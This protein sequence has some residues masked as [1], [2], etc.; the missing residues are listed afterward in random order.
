MGGIVVVVTLGT[1]NEFVEQ[2]LPDQSDRAGHAD[3]SVQLLSGGSDP[4]DL[5]EIVP[6]DVGGGVCCDC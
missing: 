2:L 6:V 1:T 5:D 4:V 3:Q